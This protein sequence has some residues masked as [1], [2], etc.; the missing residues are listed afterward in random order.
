MG[1]FRAS[2][3]R[4]LG[5]NDL[6]DRRLIRL[7]VHHNTARLVSSL[8]LLPIYRNTSSS[9]AI[10]IS[11]F[12]IRAPS[13]RTPLCMY[14]LVVHTLAPLRVV[15]YKAT[16]SGWSSQASV[17]VERRRGRGLK[18]RAWRR[19]TPAK[20]LKD[21]RSPRQRCRMGTSVKENAPDLPRRRRAE[22]HVHERVLVVRRARH[23][24]VARV[25]RVRVVE[26]APVRLRR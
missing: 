10:A 19:E 5:L 23:R 4:P 14:S 9:L 6:F 11:F 26:D 21:R 15:P 2:S 25:Q 24:D 17:G 16:I 22:L 20:V 1:S 7:E 18:A 13:S 3:V 12:K 8:L